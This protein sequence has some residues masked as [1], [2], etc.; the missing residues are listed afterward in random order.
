M[1]RSKLHSGTAMVE[2]ALILPLLLLILFCITEL[3]R[4]LY[5]QNMLTKTVG[6]ATRFLTRAYQAVDIDPVNQDCS[7]GSQWAAA[8]QDAEN[9]LIY[10]DIDGGT[11]TILDQLQL[12][13]SKPGGGIELSK[14]SLSGYKNFCMVRIYATAKFTPVVGDTLFGFPTIELTADAEGRYIG[15]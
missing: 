4:A 8:I 12:D 7:Q 13:S 15:E 10:G 5:Q 14:T 2:F 9:L 3:G 6:S 1:N 11:E